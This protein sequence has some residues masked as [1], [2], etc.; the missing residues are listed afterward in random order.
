MS[1]KEFFTPDCRKMIIYLVL[2]L[3][4]FAEIFIV[5]SVYN[6]DYIVL[7]V[8]NIYENYLTGL[9]DYVNF[10]TLTFFFYIFILFILY[11]LGCLIVL[12]IDK[13]KK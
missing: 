12:I 11:L 2:V 9:K 13:I 8:L 3:I 5:R 4:F 6:A 7:F 1:F 10:F